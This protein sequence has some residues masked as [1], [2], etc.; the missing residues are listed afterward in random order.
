MP[1]FLL[2][3]NIR[4]E[5]KEFLKSKGFSAE[6]AAKGASDERLAAMAKGGKLALLTRDTDFLNSDMFQPK[7]YSGIIV[8]RIHPPTEEKLTSALSSLLAE[9]REF[10]GKLFVV[11]EEG[12]EQV[13]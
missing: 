6:Y 5:I 9:V 7:E 2:D 4:I 11:W 12:Y 13:E 3:E 1:K 10:E 8:L